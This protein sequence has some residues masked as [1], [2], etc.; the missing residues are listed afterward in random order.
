MPGAARES[1]KRKTREEIYVS[2]E[3]G[4]AEGVQKRILGTD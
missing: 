4:Y 3:E 1:E 2:R